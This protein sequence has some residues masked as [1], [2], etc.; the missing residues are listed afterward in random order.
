MNRRTPCGVSTT[1]APCTSMPRAMPRASP[2]AALTFT[3]RPCSASAV[4]HS[5]MNGF[6]PSRSNPLRPRMQAPMTLAATALR[7]ALMPTLARSVAAVP[8]AAIRRNKVAPRHTFRPMPITTHAGP[9]I[10]RAG[11]SGLPRA[12]LADENIVR[13]LEATP[14]R[15]MLVER[16]QRAHADDEPSAPR[17][18]GTSLERPANDR[19][20]AAAGRREPGCARDGRDRRLVFG[21]QHLARTRSAGSARQQRRVGGS[22]RPG[23]LELTHALAQLRAPVA[24]GSCAASS[25]SLRRHEAVTA[26]AHGV[27]RRAA[28]SSSPAAFH[29]ALRVT[30][31]ARA[32]SS[33]E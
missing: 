2:A 7:E 17:S 32:S 18:P 14:A 5:S 6:R 20:I 24:R 3:A 11:R 19:H 22:H 26:I 9:V 16:A 21:E 27:Q 10:R 31:S 23:V 30:P 15:S 33:P 13:P 12:F 8:L 25:G 4:R 28:L 1:S 29:T